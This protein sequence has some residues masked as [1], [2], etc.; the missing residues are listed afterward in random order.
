MRKLIT[1]LTMGFLTTL[2]GCG[3]NKD[4]NTTNQPASIPVENITATN[5]QTERRA[6]SEAYCTQRNIPVYKN[7][8]SLFVDPEEKVTIRS[9][10]E[11]VD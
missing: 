5:D 4:K 1:L 10:D 9:Q 11:V 8:N 7:P 6:R 2:F 3:Q